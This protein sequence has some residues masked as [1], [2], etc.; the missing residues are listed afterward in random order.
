MTT[1]YESVDFRVKKKLLIYKPMQ[2]SFNAVGKI[3]L[4]LLF[5]LM[6]LIHIMLTL[7]KLNLINDRYLSAQHPLKISLRTTF[8]IYN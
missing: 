6:T 1:F 4:L 8:I 3:I 5:N 7:E 2:K